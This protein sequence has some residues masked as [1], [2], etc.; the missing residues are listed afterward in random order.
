MLPKSLD[1]LKGLRAAL[2]VRES[3]RGQF[4]AFGPEAQREQYAKAVERYGLHDTNIEWV[5]AHS[6]RTIATTEQ[7][8]DMLARAGRDF[9]IIVVGYVSRFARDL[10]TAVNARHDLHSVGASI[11]FADE[12]VLSSDEDS[13]E[14]WAREAVEAESYSRRLSRRISEGLEA[15]WRRYGDQAGPVP[16]GFRRATEK[17][18][19][20]EIDSDTIGRVVTLF[21]RYATGSLTIRQLAAAE[22]LHDRALTEMLK[23]PIYNGWNRRK[24][25]PD[26]A[27]PWRVAPPVSDELWERVASLRAQRSFGGGGKNPKGDLLSGLLYCQCGQHLRSDGIHGKGVRRRIHVNPCEHWTGPRRPRADWFETAIE[28]QVT[29]LQISNEIVAAVVAHLGAQPAP[30][31]AGR[32]QQQR[33]LRELALK[34]A[35]QQLTDAE[36]LGRRAQL[37][38]REE[39][40]SISLP[41]VSA[42][43]VVS[44]LGKLTESWNSSPS[45]A[46]TAIIRSIYERITV[47]GYEFAGVKLTPDAQRLGLTLALP[48]EV[49][50]VR[51]TGFEPATFGSGGRRS[52]H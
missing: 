45:E 37:L 31:E 16:L 44:Q 18:R 33:Q 49:V 51:R 41:S 15:K 2:W 13:W 5:V 50:G 14:N 26:V 40:T 29:G 10:R 47:T 39:S 21:Q 4:D 28:A 46:R 12:R 43:D 42:K 19:I 34:H 1:E 24:G 8:G 23:N 35:A 48:E 38:E 6:G 36:Y 27:A 20:L 25:E 52:I 32:L 7:F 30:D 11:L 3:T 17:P 9:D 22:G